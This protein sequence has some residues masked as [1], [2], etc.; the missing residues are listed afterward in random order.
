MLR[1][2]EATLEY[3]ASTKTSDGSPKE[4][5]ITR[6]IKVME[7]KNFSL[8]YYIMG[9]DNQRLMRNSKNLVVPRWTTEDVIGEDDGLTYELLYV[10]YNNKKYR[11]QQVLRQFRTNTRV[12]L[13]IEELR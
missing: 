13:D 11:V 9:G 6:D 12:L 8:N 10:I 5:S 2:N 3:V 7:V 1:F 4:V